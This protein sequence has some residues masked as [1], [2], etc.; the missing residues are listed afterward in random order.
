MHLIA[1]KRPTRLSYSVEGSFTSLKL[2]VVSAVAKVMSYLGCIY[3]KKNS[4]K[5]DPKIEDAQK[6]IQLTPNGYPSCPSDFDEVSSGA[7][8]L[9]S[10]DQMS[11]SDNIRWCADHNAKL[12]ATETAAEIDDV[13]DYVTA[14]IGYTDA[15]F[16]TSG[17]LVSMSYSWASSQRNIDTGVFTPPSTKDSTTT[18]VFLTIDFP[19]NFRTSTHSGEPATL[20]V[21]NKYWRNIN[22]I[23]VSAINQLILQTTLAL[24]DEIR[25]SCHVGAAFIA[26]DATSNRVL[27]VNGGYSFIVGIN[28]AA[29]INYAIVTFPELAPASYRLFKYTTNLD[30]ICIQQ[31]TGRLFAGDCIITGPTGPFVVGVSYSSYRYMIKAYTGECWQAEGVTLGSKILIAD[32]TKPEVQVKGIWEYYKPGRYSP[33]VLIHV[34]TGLC[35]QYKSTTT[36]QLATCSGS[37]DIQWLWAPFTSSSIVQLKEPKTSPERCAEYISDTKVAMAACQTPPNVQQMW[38]FDGWGRLANIHR[39]M[40]LDVTVAT[41]ATETFEPCVWDKQQYWTSKNDEYIRL[42]TELA[43]RN[44]IKASYCLN[45]QNPRVWVTNSCSKVWLRYNT[46]RADGY[47]FGCYQLDWHALPIVKGFKLSN[48]AERTAEIC[49]AKYCNGTAFVAVSHEGDCLCADFIPD[50]MYLKV[51]CDNSCYTNPTAICSGSASHVNILSMRKYINSHHLLACIFQFIASTCQT[52]VDP[53]CKFIP[54]ECSD[55]QNQQLQMSTVCYKICKGVSTESICSD[56]DWINAVIDCGVPNNTMGMA[57]SYSDTT[58]GNIATYTCAPSSL[59]WPNSTT[60]QCGSDGL[61]TEYTLNCTVIDCGFPSNV[62][63]M[64]LTTNG[65]SP[66]SIAIYTCDL[67]LYLFN[68]SFI[69]CGLDGQWTILEDPECNVIDCGVPPTI[70]NTSMTY[71]TTIVGESVEYACYPTS[72]F[73][74]N[75]TAISC[76]TD[77]LWPEPKLTCTSIDCGVLSNTSSTV[78]SYTASAPGDTAIY[79]C[80]PSD[81]YVDNSSVI[82]CGQD[83]NWTELELTCNVINC[84]FPPNIQDTINTFNSTTVGEVAMYS[85]HPLTMFEPNMTTIICETSGVWSNSQLQCSVIDCKDPPI[86]MNTIVE[87]NSTTVG[88]IA[89]YTCNPTSYYY[90]NSSSIQCNDDGN[91]SSLNLIC[92]VIDCGT[93]PAVE[94]ATVSYTSTS[95]G[96]QA[97]YTCL[98]TR[99]FTATPSFSTCGTDSQWSYVNCSEN[100]CPEAPSSPHLNVRVEIYGSLCLALYECLFG[101]EPIGGD[102]VRATLPNPISWNGSKLICQEINCG[103]PPVVPNT[104]TVST[105]AGLGATVVYK[106]VN[107]ML[108]T[109]DSMSVIYCNDDNA[110]EIPRMSCEDNSAISVCQS[111]GNWSSVYLQC[112]ELKCT[113]LDAPGLLSI[114]PAAVVGTMRITLCRPGYVPDGISTMVVTCSAPG[115]W[116]DVPTCTELVCVLP[117]VVPPLFYAEPDNVTVVTSGM[118][119]TYKCYEGYKL[120]F[121]HKL[122]TCLSNGDLDGIQPVC[123]QIYCPLF[124]LP[125]DVYIEHLNTSIGG[126]MTFHCDPGYDLSHHDPMVCTER[127]AWVGTVPVCQGKYQENLFILGMSHFK[128]NIILAK[129]CT[130][131]PSIPHAESSVPSLVF[132]SKAVYKCLDGFVFENG[133][134]TAHLTCGEFGQWIGDMPECTVAIDRCGHP[135]EYPNASWHMPPYSQGRWV[136]Y[137]CFPGFY[138]SLGSAEKLCQEITKTWDNSK[139][140]CTELAINEVEVIGENLTK[141]EIFFRW[142]G[143]TDS[144]TLP[145]HYSIGIAS[146]TFTLI[147]LILLLL[148]DCPHYRDH[149]KNLMKRNIKSFYHYNKCRHQAAALPV[150]VGHTIEERST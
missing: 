16:S 37:S 2:D 80:Y 91:W 52:F 111:N 49:R 23:K 55:L 43:L 53:S 147:P 69:T 98:P 84:G 75:S 61:W 128:N 27:L 22:F 110:W 64:S 4:P 54:K 63:T 32:C 59:Y 62:S 146:V 127:E 50:P 14:K 120:T 9:A 96:S 126:W 150:P 112:E 19:D 108:P 47:D 42:T 77:G 134:A 39:G 13:Y 28:S 10:Q 78:V 11:V 121:G 17:V 34:P 138:M 145:L 1:V 95:V 40:C 130:N 86:F 105:S 109:P 24:D 149:Y 72:K 115:T 137:K 90:A 136:R 60:S 38:L 25:V 7:C 26:K 31:D 118:N 135:P 18:C 113:E 92:T 123:E 88:S 119:V 57:L 3:I 125:S 83:G 76:G 46:L 71:T 36:I 144:D 79:K 93:P 97:D 107:G 12:F 6:F 15:T 87:F 65:T 101:Y 70:A 143:Y 100:H 56:N 94:N 44:L 67:D 141:L 81:F 8:Y 33:L 133:A 104:T 129:Y 99:H 122:R 148:I 5:L 20:I 132:Q 117:I 35:V 103:P 73:L 21:R 30:D 106:C 131:P 66:Y 74:E 116:I 140:V 114:I 124:E 29:G 142:I 51:P 89:L 85:C 45:Y 139:I 58:V 48:V 41:T 102:D 82:T 68:S